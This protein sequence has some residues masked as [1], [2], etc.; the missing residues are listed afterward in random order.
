MTRVAVLQMTTGIDPA[1]NARTIVAAIGAA[2]SG[3]ASMLFTPE[4][5]GLLDRD[6]AR[7]SRHIVPEEAS[8]VL[9]AAREAAAGAGIWVA[10]GSLAVE[11]A[12]GRW[13]NRSFTIDPTGA[14][15]ARYDKIHMFDVDLATGESWRESNAYAPGDQVVTVDHTP[16]GRLGLTICYDLR[17]P[18]LFEAL[19][20]ARCDAI[21]IPAAFTRPTGAAH[22][23]VLQRARAIEASAYVIAAAQVGTHEDGRQTYGHSLVIDPWGGVLLDLGGDEPG[24]GFAELD[25]AR[26]AEVRAQ[27]PSLANRRPIHT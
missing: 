21:A 27:L 3:G 12:D 26:I 24:L 17:F 19:G 11:R 10:L 15:A 22:W 8:P 4:M 5:S 18:A 9:A 16:L 23:H 20:Q 14:I 1:A 25:P 6:R 2:A 7:G 13:A